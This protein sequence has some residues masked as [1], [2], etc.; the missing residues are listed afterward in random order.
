MTPVWLF[1][2]LVDQ[3]CLSAIVI[4]FPGKRRNSDVLNVEIVRVDVQTGIVCDV[5]MLFGDLKQECGFANTSG[6]FDANHT[7]TPID[8][9]H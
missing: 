9:V 5:E 3:Q 1:E 7:L 6:T 8:F 2:H 4:E